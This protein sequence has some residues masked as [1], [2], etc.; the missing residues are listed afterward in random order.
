MTLAL[1]LPL[2]AAATTPLWLRDVKISPDGNKVAFCYKGDIY[3]VPTTGGQA[4]RLTSGEFYESTPVWSPDSRSIA[5][6]TD[7]NGN[8]DIYVV[9]A[10]GGTPSRLTYNSASEI[11]ETFS[12]DGKSVIFSASIQD[13]VASALYPSGRM[14]ELYSVP[15]AG[16]AAIQILATPARFVSYLPDGESFLYQDVKGFE[17]EWRKHHTSSVTRDIWLYDATNGNHVNLTNLGGE[18]TNPVVGEN[19]DYYYLSERQGMTVNVFKAS[20]KNRM[21]PQNLT[22]F[23]THPVRFLSRANNGLLAFT[24]D[25]EIYTM[26]EGAQPVKLAIN[27]IEDTTPQIDKMAVKSGARSGVASPDGK[28]VAFIYRGDVFVTSVE[29]TTTRQ[30]SAT[31]EA[32]SD[33][34]WSPDSKTLYYTSERDGRYNIYKATITRSEEESRFE[35]AT[36]IKEEPVLKADKHERTVPQVSPDG[37]KLA[38]ILDRHVLAVLDIKSGKVKELTDGSTYLQ[39]NGRF[40][41][42]WAPDSKWI[43]LEVI[44]RKHDPYTDIAILNVENGQMTNLTNS[45]Y[46]DASPRWVMG[47][48]ALMFASERYGMRNHA[49]W[50]SEMDVM[51]VFMNKK[52]MD[53]YLLGK[54]DYALYTEAEK[55]KKKK[56]EKAAKEKDG[57][58]KKDDDK[59]KEDEAKKDDIVVELGGIEDRMVRVTPQSG[60][61]Y[62]AI[63]TSDGETLY[64]IMRINSKYQLWKLN[65]REDEHAM[66]TTLPASGG[67]DIS[68]DGKTMFLL[69][70]SMRKLDPKSGKLTPISYSSTMQLDYAAEREFMFDNM[71]REVGERFYVKDMHGINWK[72]MTSHYRRFLPHISNNYDYAEMLSELLGE[73]NVSHTG[74]RYYG[75]SNSNAD[76]TASLGLLYDLNYAGDG[77]RVAEVLENGPFATASSKVAAGIVVEYINGKQI[78]PSADASILLTDLAGKRTLIGLYNPQTGERWEEVVKPISSARQNSLLHKRWVKSRAAVVDSLSNGRLGYVHISSMADGPFREVY[79][80]LLGKYNDREGIV[81]DIR[82]NGG[83]RLHEDIE[84]LFSGEKYFT[85][86]IRGIESCDMPSRRWNKPSIMLMAEPCYSNAHGT[87]WVYKRKGI[88]SLV[89]MPVPGTM[90]S[91]NWVTMQ[92]PSLVFGIPV[93]G[94]RLPDGSF[95]ENQQL[96][97]DVMVNND[98]AK[99]AQG[100][101]DQL[102][103]AVRELL[104]QIDANK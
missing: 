16:G 94:Y 73:L 71:T 69:G 12:P 62:D 42:T 41:Y 23:K 75:G 97:P 55:E 81:I 99:I 47:G 77:L 89:G 31:P 84:V 26:K 61:L 15:T 63:F 24:Y 44:A 34:C 67:F 40:N 95:L 9:D 35:Y 57:D 32:E 83:G 53:E 28:S 51:L 11:P 93:V 66:V 8:F 65:Q 103:A 72:E 18:D 74:G 14:T 43:A 21:A 2:S 90:T 49:S 4:M 98:P 80:D 10:N 7:R 60:D 19:N 1:A 30:I 100:E 27:V 59:K 64:Y 6:A 36:L 91:V 68:K 96:E 70:S 52:A 76:R 45:G 88:G 46:F 25:G 38:F 17:D 82:W 48:N 87:P 54:E 3:T 50:G 22:N 92:D 5:Y 85:Q 101:D 79:S 13:P 102:A 39:N 86:E 58:K 56:E 37:E 29:Y 20:M 78:T 33:V 104:R